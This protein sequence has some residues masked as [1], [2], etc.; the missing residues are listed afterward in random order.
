[1]TA[2]NGE[3][4]DTARGLIRAVAAAPPGLDDMQRRIWDFLAEQPRHLDEM[5]QQLALT[6]PQLA[7]SL[8]TLEMK[9]VVRSMSRYFMSKPRY[10]G[11]TCPSSDLHRGR[12]GWSGG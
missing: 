6:V 12:E 8:L 2:V 10:P 7:S 5:A 9:R 4:V 11:S 1:M 3:K